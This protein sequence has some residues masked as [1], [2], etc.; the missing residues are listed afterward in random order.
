MGNIRADLLGR[1]PDIAAQRA[2]LESRLQNIQEAKAEFYPNIELKL[3]AGLSSID[4]FNV[5][6]SSHAGMLGVLPALNLPIFTS[7][8]LRS[9]LASR[10]AEYNQQVAA[11]D[12]AVLNAMRSAADAVSDYQTLQAQAALQQRAAAIADKAAASSRRRVGAGLDN[13]LVYLQKQDEALQ[14]KMQAVQTQ[15]DWLA[16]WSNVHAQLGGGFQA[17]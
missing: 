17:E 13:K 8:A 4:A 6:R 5:I 16:A 2:L 12:Q 10:N 3:L 11:Y 1:R 7:G 9:K 14:L 15:G